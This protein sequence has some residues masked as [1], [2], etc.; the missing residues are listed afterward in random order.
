M[1]R[2]ALWGRLPAIYAAPA[3]PA[4]PVSSGRA[5][6]LPRPTRSAL[7]VRRR[8]RRREGTRPRF[9]ILCRRRPARPSSGRACLPRRW[10]SIRLGWH[11]GAGRTSCI[12]HLDL[13]MHPKNDSSLISAWMRE[14]HIGATPTRGLE[15]MEAV[16]ILYLG[17]MATGLW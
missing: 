7:A 17:I 12:V 2:L 16:Q 6:A 1:L 9:T 8:T 10:C 11:M 3:P 5:P 15:Y 14:L 13:M 4:P